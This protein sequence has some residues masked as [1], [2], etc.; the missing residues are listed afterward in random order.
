MHKYT[1]VHLCLCLSVCL[2]IY[3]STYL[4]ELLLTSLRLLLFGFSDSSSEFSVSWQATSVWTPK[5]V[6]MA[7]ELHKEPKRGHNFTYGTIQVEA[8]TMP[9]LLTL[10]SPTDLVA[11]F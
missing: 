8:K 3:L 5:Y 9:V 6:N 1:R 2:S 7:Q 4:D 10:P 11:D